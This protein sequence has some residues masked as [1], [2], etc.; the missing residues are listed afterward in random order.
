MSDQLHWLNI[1]ERIQYKV[2]LLTHKILNNTAPQCLEDMGTPVSVI[3]GRKRLQSAD[4]CKLCVS[5]TNTKFGE[6]AFSVA[7]PVPWNTQ[8]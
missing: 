4:D 6:T 7:G 8:L 2:C 3:D 5:Q 1:E